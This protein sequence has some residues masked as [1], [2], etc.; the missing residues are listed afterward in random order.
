MADD[1]FD[2][3][4][5]GFDLTW[6]DPGLRGFINE[7]VGIESVNIEDSKDGIFWQ[8]KPYPLSRL[9]QVLTQ[10]RK[11]I[12]FETF[13][14]IGCGVGTKL[15]LVQRLFNIPTVGFD[16]KTAYID[17]ANALIQA[18]NCA[19]D[20]KAFVADA[21]EWDHYVHFDCVFLN[22][23]IADWDTEVSLERHVAAELKPGAVLIL[24]NG[25]I[26]DELKQE[27]WP[28][29]KEATALKVYRKPLPH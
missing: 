11:E 1:W 23:V 22:R 24:G 18:Q 20:V 19:F 2:K 27:G 3:D 29:L 16:R 17:S 21:L 15:V 25:L 7:L 12:L 6:C 10:V 4:L 8:Y 9:G 28:V 13:L 5:A 14:E 26:Y